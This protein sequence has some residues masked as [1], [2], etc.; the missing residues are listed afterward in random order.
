MIFIS[1]GFDSVTTA[2]HDG[3]DEINLWL[4]RISCLVLFKS[5]NGDK[6]PFIY[7]YYVVLMDRF[8]NL[9]E[10]IDWLYNVTK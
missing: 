7:R 5:V 1:C 6:G 4:S 2:I 8:S 3:I 9:T 10:I